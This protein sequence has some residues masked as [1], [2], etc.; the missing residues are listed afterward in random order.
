[1]TTR[2]PFLDLSPADVQIR[3]KIVEAVTRVIDSGR[4]VGGTEVAEFENRLA[5]STGT[6]HAVGVANGLDA[7]RLIFR[8]Y[9]EMGWMAPVTR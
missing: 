4:Y 2:Y 5:V 8:A 3:N 6:R 7:L 9:I 1:M